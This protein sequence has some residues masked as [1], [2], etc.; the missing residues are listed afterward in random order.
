[1]L[2]T[3]DLL[4]F[5]LYANSVETYFKAGVYDEL[6]KYKNISGQVIS[7]W[8]ISKH[9][10]F[11]QNDE[12]LQH[13]IDNCYDMDKSDQLVAATCTCL[14]VN[15][16]KQLFAAGAPCSSKDIGDY[17]FILLTRFYLDHDL[18]FEKFKAT[19]AEMTELRQ[20][21]TYLLEYDAETSADLGAYYLILWY[22]C[23]SSGSHLNVT[24]LILDYI[25]KKDNAKEIINKK[26]TSGKNILQDS[27]LGSL[28]FA[29][30]QRMIKLSGNK[31]KVLDYY[32]PAFLN[33]T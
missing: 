17:V 28:N 24:N 4:D 19:P 15:A 16:V 27:S 3:Y 33:I 23:I 9:K 13:L 20:M 32:A 8:M 2:E 5:S 14:N 26:S 1:M 18:L 21:V 10:G 22:S 25:E 12:V 30:V 29:T 11:F 6:K 7:S 31:L